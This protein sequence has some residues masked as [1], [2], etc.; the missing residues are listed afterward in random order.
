MSINLIFCY[1]F[2]YR[3]CQIISISWAIWLSINSR[4]CYRICYRICHKI[5]HKISILYV[6]R[7]SINLKFYYKIYYRNYYLIY[8]ISLDKNRHR[9]CNVFYYIFCN[10][11]DITNFLIAIQRDCAYYLRNNR[12]YNVNFW[13]FVNFILYYKIYRKI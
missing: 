6:I 1:I 4:F 11:I 5:Y 8:Y 7:L 9:S 3:I 10:I 12:L 2:Y 13:I